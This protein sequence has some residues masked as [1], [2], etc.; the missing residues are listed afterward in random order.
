MQYLPGGT[1]AEQLRQGPVKLQLLA[2]IIER[3][4][5][6]LD[7]AHA[8][9]IIHQDVK[10]GNIIFNARGE[11]FLSDFGIAVLAEA[12]AALSARDLGFTPNYV[13]PER[14]R[15]YRD[16]RPGDVDGRSDIYSLGI[17]LFEALTGHVPFQ[18]DSPLATGLAHVEAPIPR[19]GKINPS[20]VEAAQ[21]IIERALAK[22]PADR[23][24]TA[25]E[26]AQVVKDLTSGRWV[27]GKL[28]E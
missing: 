12:T 25:R 14:V 22:S 21:K 19:I 26:L 15:A 11:A 9:H 28:L 3:V 6:A 10:P 2:P 5:A 17:V 13:S 27:L 1:L 23:Y 16:K 8:Q 20:L 4:A 24:Q 7:E 18:A